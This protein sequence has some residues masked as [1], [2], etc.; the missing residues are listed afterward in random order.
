M[1]MCTEQLPPGGYPVAVKYTISYQL[2]PVVSRQRTGL[3]FK[4]LFGHFDPLKMTLQHVSKRRLPVTQRRGVLSYKK[5]LFEGCE[6]FW[7]SVIL[8]CTWLFTSHYWL[9]SES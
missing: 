3:I 2:V 9:M 5:A 1:Y 8:I 4:G 6:R 7:I